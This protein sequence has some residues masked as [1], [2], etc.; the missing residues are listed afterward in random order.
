[1]VHHAGRRARKSLFHAF[2]AKPSTEDEMVLL[3]RSS[4]L[5]GGAQ[6]AVYQAIL[7]TA[8]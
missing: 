7:H 3:L 8:G 5:A 1:M 2:R 4:L 6:L